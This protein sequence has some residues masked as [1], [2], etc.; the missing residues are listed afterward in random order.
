MRFVQSG[1]SAQLPAF[2]RFYISFFDVDGDSVAG[3]SVYE[4][5]AVLGAASLATAPASTLQVGTFH[6]SEALY[7]M[8]SESSGANH[9]FSSDPAAPVGES[10]GAA[11]SFELVG[12]SSFRMLVGGR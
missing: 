9:D 5:Q 10:Q 4:L 8:S 3:N 11:A 12:T 7:V 6:P 1:L 2:E